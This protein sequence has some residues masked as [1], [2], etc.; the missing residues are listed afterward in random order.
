[1]IARSSIS[2]TLVIRHRIGSLCFCRVDVR[3]P[4][5]QR[6]SAPVLSNKPP[7]GCRGS[8][9]GWLFFGT[10]LA[11]QFDDC[12]VVFKRVK[13]TAIAIQPTTTHLTMKALS[14]TVDVLDAEICSDNA[15]DTS[16]NATNNSSYPSDCWIIHTQNPFSLLSL[17]FK[18]SGE[19]P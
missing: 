8:G 14:G 12:G 7:P 16:K 3:P 10:V 18:I 4:S 2:G 1:M 17:T 5:R 15:S 19:S 13:K 6:A 9:V 11:E